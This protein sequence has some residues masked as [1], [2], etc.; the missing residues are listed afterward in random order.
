MDPA[1]TRSPLLANA[2]HLLGVALGF[3]AM[4]WGAQVYAHTRGLTLLDPVKAE[5][6]S[7]QL[8]AYVQREQTED[9]LIIGSSR[10]GGGLDAPPLQ[11]RLEQQLDRPTSVYKLGI[12]GLLPQLIADLLE[13][14]V[15]ARPPEELLVIAIE[16]RYF[17]RP[18][19]IDAKSKAGPIDGEWLAA[20]ESAERL[21]WLDGLRTC[22]FVWWWIDAAVT[23]RAEAIEARLGEVRP[24]DEKARR[25][26]ARGNLRSNGKR[27]LFVL[28][29]G[30]EWK[31]G[32][33]EGPALRAWE[34]CLDVLEDLPCDVLLVRMPLAEG[35]D[36]EHMPRMFERLER[37]IVG[38]A[39]ARGIDYVDL[40]REP[41]PSEPWAFYSLT[42][43]NVEGAE[44]TT[45]ALVSEVLAPRLSGGARDR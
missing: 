12:P 33:D 14:P 10:V 11:S 9:V 35:F 44:A 21:R 34:R 7:E 15:R 1:N 20:D 24:L 32:R 42:H 6:R 36:E 18:Q 25:L 22:W 37:D 27:D 30:H 39:R 23:A 38:G 29:P 5:K 31:W 40:N 43:L 8:L 41:F 19:K 2:L 13:G 45:R 16:A 4:A 26:R 17:C 3:V 28:P